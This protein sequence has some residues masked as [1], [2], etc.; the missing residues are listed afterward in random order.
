MH[1]VGFIIRIYHDA[2]S[3]EGKTQGDILKSVY[4][5]R[6]IPSVIYVVYFLHTPGVRRFCC[7]SDIKFPY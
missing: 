6:L 5:K 1:L 7:V 4:F 2:L 3:P